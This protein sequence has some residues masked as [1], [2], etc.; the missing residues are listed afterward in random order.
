MTCTPVAVTP[1]PALTDHEF[2]L[3]QR[4]IHKVAGIWL[5]DIKRALLVARLSR[6]LRDLGLSSYEAYYERVSASPGELIRMLDAVTTNETHFFRERA[7][8][9]LLADRVCPELEARAARG[10]RART[11]RIWSAACSTGE[12]PYSLAMLLHDRL[13]ALGWT[14]DILASDLST[15]VLDHARAAI[16]RVDR[17][18]QVPE[19]WVRRYFHRGIGPEEGRARLI[20]A[21]RSMVHFTRINLRDEA[22]AADAPYDLIFCRNV[23]IYFDAPSRRDVLTR[24]LGRLAPGGLLFLGHAESLLGLGAAV[25]TVIPAVYQVPT[26]EPGDSPSC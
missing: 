13:G 14:I 1:P 21:L 4:L 9:D 20:P 15:R 19:G 7:Q 3:F 24:M 25:R 2:A 10:L 17:L 22:W 18:D 12:E 23:L 6:R 8:F 5:A 16:Y 11:L 26:T